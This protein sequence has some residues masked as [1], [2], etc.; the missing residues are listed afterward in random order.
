MLKRLV[1]PRRQH[2]AGSSFGGHP[3]R[4]KSDAAGCAG[5]HEDLIFDGLQPWSHWQTICAALVRV[6]HALT[7]LLLTMSD[8][9]TSID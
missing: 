6:A 1:I 4:D 7:V 2:D 3:R 5:D 9:L 8:A